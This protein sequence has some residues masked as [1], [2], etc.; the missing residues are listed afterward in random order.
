VNVSALVFRPDGRR[1]VSASGSEMKIWD[2]ATSQELY[3]FTASA[4][5]GKELSV[6]GLAFS[7]DGR[8]LVAA[9]SSGLLLWDGRDLK[10]EQEV[11]REALSLLDELFS[12]PLPHQAVLEEI[13]ASP[14]AGEAVRRRALE[15]ADH[16]R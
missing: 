3:G 7:P 13:R 14:S 9:G 2:V 4:G 1:L 11:E 6:D 5:A 15:L 16:Y 12:P 8:L 10:Q